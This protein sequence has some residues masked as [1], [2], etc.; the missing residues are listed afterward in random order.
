MHS[1]E[2]HRTF[3]LYSKAA[4]R[5][6]QLCSGNT[7]LLI[8]FEQ[9]LAVMTLAICAA[10][11][12]QLKKSSQLWQIKLKPAR[13]LE[14]E[15]Q[16]YAKADSL[17]YRNWTKNTVNYKIL[18]DTICPYILKVVKTTIWR[19]KKIQNFKKGSKW[20]SKFLGKKIYILYIF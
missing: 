18:G 2:K 4:F 14:A 3:I 8:H 13:F 5:A 11:N 9:G 6:I 10:A 12:L 1:H 15:A 16:R 7:G 17:V 19:G 20:K